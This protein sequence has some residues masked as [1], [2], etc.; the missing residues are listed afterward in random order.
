MYDDNFIL[1]GHL[2]KNEGIN[3]MKISIEVIPDLPEP[4]AD[5]STITHAADGLA[6]D[7]GIK[8][9]VVNID[10]APQALTGK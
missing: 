1:T 5:T 6:V 10:Q 3:R 2:N 9:G 4:S 8:Q 7:S